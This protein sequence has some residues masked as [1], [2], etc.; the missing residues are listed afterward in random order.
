LCTMFQDWGSCPR[1]DDCTY[2]HGEHEL[3]GNKS[4]VSTAQ[5]VAKKWKPPT[6]VVLPP[7]PGQVMAMQM[8]PG[9]TVGLPAQGPGHFLGP[10]P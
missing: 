3:A 7:T 2:A 8:R 5:P 10:E 1:G 9:P 4:A 6:S